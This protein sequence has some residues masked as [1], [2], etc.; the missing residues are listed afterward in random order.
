MD[1]TKQSDESFS[2]AVQ[3]SFVR[4]AKDSLIWL[5]ALLT[6]QPDDL[7]QGSEHGI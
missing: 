2:R 3:V 6:L 5:L 4:N 1:V 7:Q